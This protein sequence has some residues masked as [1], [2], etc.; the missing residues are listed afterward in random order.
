MNYKASIIGT[1]K[2]IRSV[3]NLGVDFA[4]LG[5]RF[6]ATR[7]TLISDEYRKMVLE[8]HMEDLVSSKAIL[9]SL[10]PTPVI[11]LNF[12]ILSSKSLFDI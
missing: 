2:G 1:G 8:S 9:Q 6:L 12:F 3:E 11:S 10:N 7:E 4:Y 5:T